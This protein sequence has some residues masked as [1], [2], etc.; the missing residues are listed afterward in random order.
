VINMMTAQDIPRL[1]EV[2]TMY[3]LDISEMPANLA[4][5]I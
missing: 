2:A 4:D 3:A 5:L 1:Q